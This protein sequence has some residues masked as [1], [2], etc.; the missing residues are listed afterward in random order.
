[1]AEYEVI[2]EDNCDVVVNT[3]DDTDVV[4]V[5]EEST[6][7][8]L[9][10]AVDVQVIEESTTVIEAEDGSVIVSDVGVQGP[11]AEEN[12]AFAQRVDFVGDTVIYRAEASPGTLDS[13]NAWRIRRI[14]FVGPEED[15][16]TEW[17][18]GV[19]DFTKIWNDRATYSYV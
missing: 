4:S 2:V 13:A 19:S 6:V 8:V 11:A 7:V 5:V 3:V 9:P 15:A 16:I 14:T 17:A 18:D 12:V 10:D 1:M